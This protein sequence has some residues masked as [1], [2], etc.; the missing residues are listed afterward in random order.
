MDSATRDHLKYRARPQRRQSVSQVRLCVGDEEMCRI[1]G[2]GAAGRWS[3]RCCQPGPEPPVCRGTARP[4]FRRSCAPRFQF[5]R[6]SLRTP[7][8][9]HTERCSSDQ[10]GRWRSGVLWRGA[11]TTCWRFGSDP[12][13]VPKNAPVF[14]EPINSQFCRWNKVAPNRGVGCQCSKPGSEIVIQTQK[15]SSKRRNSAGQL[16][17]NRLQMR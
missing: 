15:R 10:L 9:S 3:H 12:L 4:G 8:G 11:I 13:S 14:T 5:R 1:V 6:C 2:T 7:R 17:A 16:L